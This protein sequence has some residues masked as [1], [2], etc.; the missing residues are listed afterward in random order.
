MGAQLVKEAATKTNDAAGDGTTTATV[1]AEGMISE[2]LKFLTAGANAISMKNGI[3]KAVEAVVTDLDK[4]KKTISTKEEYAAVATI[5]AQDTQV[6]KI[7]AD[8]MD[9]VGTDG[10]V[11]VEA[12]QT[13]GLEKEYAI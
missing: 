13:M 3:M 9:E 4:Q 2:G 1:L 12:G 5:S 6:G 10:V 8:V 11:T 7:I